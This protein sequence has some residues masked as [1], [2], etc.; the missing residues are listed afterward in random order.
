MSIDILPKALTALIDDFGN[1]PGVG[2]RTAERYAYAV[3]RRNPK[4]AK[5]LA[6]S[7][8]QLHDRVKTCPKTFALIDSDDDVSPLYA[9]SNRNKK[10]VCVVE[11]PLDIVAIER[12]G[13]F[14]GTY[15]VLGGVISPIDNIGPEQLHIPRTNW[16]YK[17]RRRFRRL[18]SL[19]TLQLRASRPRCF[20]KDTS[21]KLDWVQPSHA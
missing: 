19:R 7:L 5:Q 4:S 12:T 21:K 18:L 1:L 6:H 10:I 13:Q 2:P 11:E 9:D 3:L 20:C 17:N 14:L 8:D 16:A 15:H